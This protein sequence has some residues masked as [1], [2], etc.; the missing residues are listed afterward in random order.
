M[1]STAMTNPSSRLPVSPR[2]IRAGGKFHRRKPAAA[3]ES[4]MAAT[5]KKLEASGSPAAKSVAAT[6]APIPAARPSSPSMRFMALV[7]PT[8]QSS[9]TG[10]ESAPRSQVPPKGFVR[11][12]MRLP[13][14]ITTR[15]A[16]ACTESLSRASAPRAS[17]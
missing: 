8:I 12:P 15:P 17:S 3:P 16:S 4:A 11:I 6:M 13:E 1:P 14:A 10:T 5:G 2:K 7:I 9:V